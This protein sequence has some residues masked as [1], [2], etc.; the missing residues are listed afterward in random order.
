MIRITVRW[1]NA[2]TITTVLALLATVTGWSQQPSLTWLGTLG[3]TES[4]ANGVSA[5]GRVVVGQARNAAGWWR[6][7]RWTASG[8]MQDLGTLGGAE[9][10]ASGV[11][12]DGQVIVG[13]SRNTAGF[14]RAFRWTASGGDARHRHIGRQVW[15]RFGRLRGRKR[16]GRRG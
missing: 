4:R 14:V 8:G 16:R 6:A 7:F 15:G 9:S 11:S 13:E 1:S 12:A 10:V 2:L 3:G 5:D